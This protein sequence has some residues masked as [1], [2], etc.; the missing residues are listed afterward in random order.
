MKDHTHTFLL[1]V[2]DTP[3]VLVRIAQVFARRGSNIRALHVQ[4]RPHAPWSTMTIS[5]KNVQHIGQLQL[6]LEKLVDIKSVVVQEQTTN[7]EQSRE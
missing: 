2:R 5:V 1:E 3:G 7:K 4:P 6:Q